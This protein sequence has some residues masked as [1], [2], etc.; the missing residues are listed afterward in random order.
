[1]K[2]NRHLPQLHQR[3]IKLLFGRQGGLKRLKIFGHGPFANSKKEQR[4]RHWM[5]HSRVVCR[6]WTNT[7][8]A[9]EFPLQTS[10]PNADTRSSHSLIQVLTV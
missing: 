6:A 2:V 8:H 3:L 1:V 9:S 7:H 4:A 5:G 10:A